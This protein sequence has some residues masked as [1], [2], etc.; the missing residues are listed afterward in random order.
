MV[1]GVFSGEKST[2]GYEVEITRAERKDSRLYLYYLEKSPPPDAIVTQVLT[3]PYHLV[4]LP[5][6]DA[7]VVFVRES[8]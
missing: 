7:R 3:Q 1:A 8:K 2:G 4:K 5:R 6:D